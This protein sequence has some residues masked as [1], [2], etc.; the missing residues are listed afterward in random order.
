L[1]SPCKPVSASGS[2]VVVAIAGADVILFV[3]GGTEV[4]SL[5][6]ELGAGFIGRREHE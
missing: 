1:A 4:V 6:T 2:A 5:G 3:G